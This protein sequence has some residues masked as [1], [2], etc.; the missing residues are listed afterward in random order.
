MPSLSSVSSFVDIRHRLS[1]L[2]CQPVRKR[3]CKELGVPLSQP[4]ILWCDNLHATYLFANSVF[5]ARTKHMEIDF[6]FVS[7]KVAH[8][9]LKV[10]FIS[11]KF[12][13]T[14]IEWKFLSYWLW[15]DFWFYGKL[16]GKEVVTK[17]TILNKI[18]ISLKGI[19]LEDN[20]LI[21]CL[22]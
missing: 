8:H 4:L 5:H 22:K 14:L 9:E 12:N 3:V 21:E 10:Q 16:V 7:E 18:S 15:A 1:I 13:S 17:S 20:Y 6:H 11:L 19:W 2:V